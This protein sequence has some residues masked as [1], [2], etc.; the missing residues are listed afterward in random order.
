MKQAEATGTVGTVG[1]VGVIGGGNM[2]GALAGGLL[3]RGWTTAVAERS[4]AGREKLARDCPAATVVAKAADFPFAPELLIL[5]V[6]PNQLRDCCAA[7]RTAGLSPS[8]TVAS[9]AAGARWGTV[10]DWLGGW[11]HLART[12]PNTPALLGLGVTACFALPTLD[13]RRRE[14]VDRAMAAAG[15]TMWVQCE[16]DLDALTA[17]SG[18]GPAYGYLLAE[19]MAAAAEGMG[20]DAATARTATAE[21]LR[22]AAEMLLRGGTD[23]AGGMP[24]PAGL[25]RAVTSPGGATAAALEVFEA[26][27]FRGMTA[28]AMAAARQRA[29]AIGDELERSS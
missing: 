22:G 8:T 26:A 5:A 4:A 12:M 27:D 16:A 17:L 15:T 21:T 29:A 11:P 7:L 20:V 14:L 19:A 9:V 2:G 1:R 23:G 13:A 24:D 25:R 28:R 6:K 18:C 10:S 3:A